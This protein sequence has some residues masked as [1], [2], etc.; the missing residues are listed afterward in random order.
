MIVYLSDKKSFRDDVL[1]NRIEEIIHEAY[2]RERRQSVGKSEITSWKNSLG[3]IERILSDEQ[4]PNEAGVAIEYGV[5]SSAKRIDIIITGSNAAKEKT[6]VIVEL[7]QW[8]DVEITAMDAVVRTFVGRANRDLLHPSYQAWSYAMLLEDYSEVV[9]NTPVRLQPCAYLHNCEDGASVLHPRYRDHLRRAPAFLKDDAARLRSFIRDHVRYGDSGQIIYEI[10]A[11]VIRP[12]KNLADS[13]L[14]LLK[15]KREFVLI[16]DQK[17]VYE[18]ALALADKPA[19]G[20][21]QTLIVEGG[22][23]TGKSVVAINLLVELTRR[24]KLVKYVTKNAAPRAV[25]EF[26]L[27]GEFKKSRISNLFTS[28]GSFVDAKSDEFGA[29]LVD[30]AHR[31]N[32]KSG[33]FNNLGVNQ[34]KELIDASKLSV[35]FIDDAQRVTLRDIGD[36]ASIRDWARQSGSEVTELKLES[37]FRCGGSDGYLAWV[38]QLLGIR[39]T[40]NTTL[41]GIPYDFKVCD[42]AAEL[43]DLI[44]VRNRITNKARMVA[45]Y[46]WDW[47]SKKDPNRIDISFQDEDFKAQWNFADASTP[48]L[49]QSGSVEQVGCIHTC[50]GLEL[51]YVGVILGPDL[52]VRDGKWVEFPNRRAKTDASIKGYKKLILDKS[53]VGRRRILEIIRN[54]YRTLMTRG[55][56]GCFVYS[57]D[58]ETNAFLKVA[59]HGATLQPA[60]ALETRI[61]SPETYPFAILSGDR[62]KPF[63]NCVPCYASLRAAAGAF[64]EEQV[65]GD[66][67]WAE[68]PEPLVPK[69]GFFVVKVVGESMNR[70]IPNGSWCLFRSD[71]VGS[72]QG[73]VVLVQ[74]RD[75]EDNGADGRYTVK[76]YRSERAPTEEGWAHSSI[77]L[78][79]NSTDP[80][81]Q[82]IVLIPSA[83]QDFRVVGELIAVLG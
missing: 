50:Q 20:A 3:F 56:K 63:E 69:R 61:E 43:R 16:D 79:P 71:P 5:P 11:G 47:V 39:Q 10:N 38:D 2:R 42:S 62:A 21:K 4:I 1:T 7:K 13:L 75:I 66:C 36:I 34:I 72:R 35:F 15:G 82:E 67:I 49:L 40:A 46:C 68:L 78:Q 23:G 76:V 73:K 27:K 80:T 54:T 74:H 81:F 12:S 65:A 17:V 41:E 59:A 33:M 57:V 70:R 25:Y 52:V 18:T 30:E 45:G 53:D 29:L 22:P 19:N 28:S 48:W 55:Q 32:E 64:S 60:Q 6:A 77:T 24:E 8:T 58:P 44:R 31:L 83:D 14:A 51:D 9:R 37:Q 26:K